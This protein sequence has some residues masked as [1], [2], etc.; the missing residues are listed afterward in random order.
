MIGPVRGYPRCMT[1]TAQ[2]LQQLFHSDLPDPHLVV[3]AG[4]AQIVPTPAD[5]QEGLVVASRAELL[6]QGGG[7]PP[8]HEELEQ[9]AARL[10]SAI[11]TMGG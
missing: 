2:L 11:S 3:E 10:D 9:L 4:E 8:S 1:V 6:A 7:R 5:G